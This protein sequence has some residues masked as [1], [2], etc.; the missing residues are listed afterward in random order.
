MKNYVKQGNNIPL[1]ANKN[2]TSG[3]GTVIG[4]IF[5]VA[6]GDVASGAEI[7]FSTVGVFDLAKT[8]SQTFAQGAK[9]YFNN[10]TNAATSTTSTNFMIGTAV[11]A[12]GANDASVRVRLD[13]IA[14]TA[15]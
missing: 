6:T 1:I 13:G 12:A 9:V 7:E 4:S 10:S 14:V 15:S 8:A 11:A 2:L 5:G 3:Q